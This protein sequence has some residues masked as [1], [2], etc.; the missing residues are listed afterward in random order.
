M[1]KR[2]RWKRFQKDYLLMLISM[3][4]KFIELIYG[5]FSAVISCKD[6]VPFLVNL[7]K[8]NIVSFCL[9]CVCLI[10]SIAVVLAFTGCVFGDKAIETTKDIVRECING[11]CYEKSKI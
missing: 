11:F 2:Q 4:R 7:A 3:K 10:V 9:V 8:T 1:R 6:F 5:F